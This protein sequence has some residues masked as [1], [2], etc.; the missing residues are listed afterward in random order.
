MKEVDRLLFV[1]YKG[2]PKFRCKLSRHLH[3]NPIY[4]QYHFGRQSIAFMGQ[5][6]FHG[7]QS[8]ESSCITPSALI[9]SNA[10]TH[11]CTHAHTHAHT[12]N[13]SP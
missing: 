8:P 6:V 3:E 9:A 10:H 7:K 5:E 2:A 11:T 4:V 12:Y 1:F 13:A